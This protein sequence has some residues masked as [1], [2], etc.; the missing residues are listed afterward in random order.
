MGDTIGEEQV[1]IIQYSL[2]VLFLFLCS[3]VAENQLR[4]N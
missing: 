1:F 3:K 4:Y 2:L